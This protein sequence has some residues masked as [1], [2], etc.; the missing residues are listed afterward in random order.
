MLLL[1]MFLNISTHL[2][3]FLN[4]LQRVG[5]AGYIET[6]NAVFERLVPYDVHVLEIMDVDD[7]LVIHKKSS[8][9]PD[10]YIKQSGYR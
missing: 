1:F 4:E 7:E 9:K 8:A 10:E 2:N 3:Y 5:R 6:P